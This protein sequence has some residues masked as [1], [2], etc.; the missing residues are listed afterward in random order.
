MGYGGYPLNVSLLLNE[1]GGEQEK[2]DRRR[3]VEFL[4]RLRKLCDEYAP[5]AQYNGSSFDEETRQ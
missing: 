4:D 5:I 3:A 1:S 2:E